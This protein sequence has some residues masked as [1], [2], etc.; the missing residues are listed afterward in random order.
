MTSLKSQSDHIFFFVGTVFVTF[1]FWLGPFSEK[2]SGTCLATRIYPWTV[3]TSHK[4]LFYTDCHHYY[5]WPYT[6]FEIL[7]Q[8]RK[9][10]HFPEPL[11][12]YML[13]VGRYAHTGD[14]P[15]WHASHAR[16]CSSP[17]FLCILHLWHHRRTVVGRCSSTPMLPRH[18]HVSIQCSVCIQAYY[19]LCG[20]KMCFVFWHLHGEF[21]VNG[22]IFIKM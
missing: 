11:V 1:S 10:K 19:V 16:Q 21:A 8:P 7:L 15:A 22:F 2:H 9:R 5:M 17:L 20:N 12:H 14:A 3:L 4:C 13:F 6:W 18:Q